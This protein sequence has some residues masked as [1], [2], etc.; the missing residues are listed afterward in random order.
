LVRNVKQALLDLLATDVD[1]MT[2]M[3]ALQAVEDLEVVTETRTVQNCC[4]LCYNSQIYDHKFIV[5]SIEPDASSVP[6][7]ENA[8]A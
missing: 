8:S 5:A 6:C 4:P 2:I 3:Q 1:L 7:G